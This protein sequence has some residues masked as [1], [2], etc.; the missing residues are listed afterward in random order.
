MT[1][2]IK[3]DRRG[4]EL[5][6]DLQ[7]LLE[8]PLRFVSDRVAEYI[9]G[10][11]VATLR[12]WRYESRGPRYAKVGSSVRYRVSWLLEFMNAKVIEPHV[13]SE[14]DLRSRGF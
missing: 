6:T 4:A 2:Q 14:T 5:S 9:T 1:K 12:R 11:P 3:S 7:H 8:S 13:R 10:I